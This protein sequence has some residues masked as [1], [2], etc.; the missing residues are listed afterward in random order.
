MLKPLVT[1][2]LWAAFS[3]SCKG[4]NKTEPPGDN[5]KSL[6]QNAVSSLGANSGIR[7]IEQDRS[8]VIW[9]ATYEG[10][11]RYDGRSF[12]KIT[13]RVAL[14]GFSS[15]LEDKKGNLWFASL[16][17]GVFYYDGKSFRN[18]T[19]K[20]GLASNGVITIYEDQAGNIWFGTDGGGASRY[21]G[22][23]FS[24][25]SMNGS[26]VSS[27]VED[28]AGK[29]WF[30]TRGNVQIY[31]GITLTTFMDKDGKPFANVSTVIE[32]QKGNIWLGG[33]NGLWRYD[34]HLF[35][36]F[37]RDFVGEVYEDEKGNIWTS[38][39]AADRRIWILS[40][41]DEKSL[42]GREPDVTEV[43]PKTGKLIFGISEANDGSILFGSGGVLYRYD[44]NTLSA[45]KGKGSLK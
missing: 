43:D 35:T 42:S 39:E 21:D 36:N 24:N 12:T 32:D 2:H 20:D 25:L 37:S 28:E 9:I 23:S 38:S 16:G 34:G 26:V 11:F 45:L 7:D 27:I 1:L 31:D 41:Y 33:Q 3:L 13:A 10:V 15:V 6:S 4:Q 18:F 5:I 44:G 14:A 22:K 8:G 19:V 40:R 29:L 30:C 17:S